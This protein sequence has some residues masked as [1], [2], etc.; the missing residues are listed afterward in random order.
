MKHKNHSSLR[1]ED[2]KDT[3]NPPDALGQRL[4]LQLKF[5]LGV[6]RATRSETVGNFACHG[7]CP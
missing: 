6:M 7:L 3:Q 4:T 1:R 5:C 2:P